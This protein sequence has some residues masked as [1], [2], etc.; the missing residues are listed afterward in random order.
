MKCQMLNNIYKKTN[1][2]INV[3]TENQDIHQKITSPVLQASYL[4]PTHSY[5]SCV[6]Y[7]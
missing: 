5:G 6:L 2:H 7:V 1:G 3:Q 4:G